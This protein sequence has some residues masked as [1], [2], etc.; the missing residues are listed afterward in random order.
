MRRIDESRVAELDTSL[1]GHLADLRGWPD[2]DRHDEPLGPRFNRAR[3]CARFTRMGDRGGNGLQGPAPLEHLFVL[4]CASCSV[5]IA[6]RRQD[7][8]PL[9]LSPSTEM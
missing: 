6:S 2:E 3:Q 1:L 8:R 7:E 4:A 9:F 5:H